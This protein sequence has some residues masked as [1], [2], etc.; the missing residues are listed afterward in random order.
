MSEHSLLTFCL[1]SE[2]LALVEAILQRFL[3]RDTQVWVFGSRVTG[4]IKK[5]SDLDL[6]LDHQGVAL[7]ESV[8]LAMKEA[9]DESPLPYKVA[10]VDW[11]TLSDSFK[12]CPGV[13]DS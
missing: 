3:P 12:K 5:F 8:L 9:F 1:T 2:Q 11:N 13:V 6:L 4:T 7:A 10:V